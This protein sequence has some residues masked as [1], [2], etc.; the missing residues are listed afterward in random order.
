MVELKLDQGLKFSR[1]VI[2]KRK[3]GIL[4]HTSAHA[5]PCIKFLRYLKVHLTSSMTVGVWS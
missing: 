3:E 4:G 1:M 2:T 5:H